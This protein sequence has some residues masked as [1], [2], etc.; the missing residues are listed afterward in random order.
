MAKHLKG[1]IENMIFIIIAGI[2]MICKEALYHSPQEIRCR[3][4]W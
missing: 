3:N 1:L 4:F 2:F